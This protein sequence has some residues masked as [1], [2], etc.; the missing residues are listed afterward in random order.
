LKAEL[1]KHPDTRDEY[2]AL[3][4]EF[5]LARELIAARTSAGLTQAEVEPSAW[6]LG[7]APL[8]DWKVARARHRYAVCNATPRPW[9]AA[10][11]CDWNTHE[12]AK[13]R[14]GL[15]GAKAGPQGAETPE[16][17][18]TIVKTEL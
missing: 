1:L 9:A 16:Q 3:A 6:A 17:P 18:L 10:L 5:S 14:R 15:T 13:P 12:P 11:W 7:K 4:D 8:R 2:E